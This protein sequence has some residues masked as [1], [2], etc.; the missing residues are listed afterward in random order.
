MSSDPVP[1][2]YGWRTW[3]D[4]VREMLIG[5][6]AGIAILMIE[7]GEA[8]RFP[9]MTSFLRNMLLGAGATFGSRGLETILSWAIEQS[10]IPTIFRSGI[11]A[12]GGWI[13]YLVALAIIGMTL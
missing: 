2:T 4:P 8:G 11:Y 7:S 6:A 13:G 9:P 12:F 1:R 5:A 10:R 3:G